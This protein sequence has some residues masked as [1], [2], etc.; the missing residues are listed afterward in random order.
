MERFLKV[1]WGVFVSMVRGGMGTGSLVAAS[2]SGTQRA[3]TM[4]TQKAAP[5]LCKV[6][7]LGCAVLQFEPGSRGMDC[8]F[9]LP[10]LS[11]LSLQ[12]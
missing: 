4:K 11:S 8:L 5:H 9:P 1:V 6:F 2:A 10:C 3:V 12:C 7:I